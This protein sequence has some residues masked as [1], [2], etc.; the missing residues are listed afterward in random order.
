MVESQVPTGIWEFLVHLKL[1]EHDINQRKKQFLPEGSWKS[2]KEIKCFPPPPP[3]F[4]KLAE[5]IYAWDLYSSFG[6]S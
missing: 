4:L 3:S 1:C 6:Q 5:C 2:D